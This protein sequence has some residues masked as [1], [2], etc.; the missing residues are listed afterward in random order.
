MVKNVIN[1]AIKKII[2]SGKVAGVLAASP[3]SIKYWIE[4]G[5][6]FITCHQTVV[7]AEALGNFVNKFNKVIH[8]LPFYCKT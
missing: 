1:D 8:S 5:V 6:K 7:L 2:N 3:D 4:L